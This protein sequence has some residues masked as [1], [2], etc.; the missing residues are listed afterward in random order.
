MVIVDKVIEYINFT[1]KNPIDRDIVFYLSRPHT[2]GERTASEIFRH[3]S[4]YN[5]AT[6]DKRL[7][8]LRSPRMNALTRE[9]AAWEDLDPVRWEQVFIR[10]EP[11]PPAPRHRAPFIYDISPALDAKLRDVR[12]FAHVVGAIR[13]ARRL[14]HIAPDHPT[15]SDTAIIQWFL[16]REERGIFIPGPLSPPEE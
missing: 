11:A 8:A 15:L 6:F 4:P 10:K 2:N 16:D 12:G 1:F 13:T 14:G 9:I 7:E 5:R 3:I